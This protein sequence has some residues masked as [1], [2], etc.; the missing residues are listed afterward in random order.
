MKQ[1]AQDFAKDSDMAPAK[2]ES[3]CRALGQMTPSIFHQRRRF[4]MFLTKVLGESDDLCRR[5]SHLAT[6]WEIFA[7]AC[8]KLGFVDTPN[9]RQRI[10]DRL[11]ALVYEEERA[12][13]LVEE[14]S[15]LV[16]TVCVQ[17]A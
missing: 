12:L 10:T 4:V 5:Y 14:K 11:K 8:L 1:F 15:R 7:N 13:Q 2:F 6:Q 9:L 17:G 16:K 3:V